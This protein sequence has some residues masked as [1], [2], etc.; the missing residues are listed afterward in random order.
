MRGSISSKLC[1]ARKE[2]KRT[3]LLPKTFSMIIYD[4]NRGET[5][6]WKMEKRME[7]ELRHTFG[8]IS[9]IILVIL[10]ATGP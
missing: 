4:L 8:H 6:V 1:P 5:K 10:A 3:K 7:V 2:K 9:D